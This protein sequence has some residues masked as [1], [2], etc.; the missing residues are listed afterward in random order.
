MME[1]GIDQRTGPMTRAQDGLPGR[2]VC[3]RAAT[4]RPRTESQAGIDS[5]LSSSGSAF[6]MSK[7][8]VSPGLIF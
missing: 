4:R 1:E 3:L 5:P 2:L 6:G 7:A 8:I